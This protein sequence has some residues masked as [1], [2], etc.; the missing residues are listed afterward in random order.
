[1]RAPSARGL[2]NAT[3]KTAKPV[4]V[5]DEATGV[6]SKVAERPRKKDGFEPTPREATLA[7]LSVERS[8][9][10]RFG[11]IWEPACGD[12]AMTRV[13]IEQGISVVA[14]DLVDRGA[15]SPFILRSFYDFDRAPSPCAVTNPPFHETSWGHGKARW[16][17][18]ALD[19]LG[20]EY[21]ALLMPWSW[22]AA[23]GLG[24]VWDRR[25]PARIYLMRFRLD[26]TGQG[27]NPSN[28]A[29]FVWDAAALKTPAPLLFMLDRVDDRQAEMFG[30][31]V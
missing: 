18:H 5:R 10:L 13:M 22:P 26:F 29:W 27:A 30:G 24:A 15:P 31:G 4:A 20:L 28:H 12:G 25:P 2:F 6:Y 16:V 21:M 11:A 8:Q 19:T 7:F 1:M 14:S 3:G 17:T 23:A 9:L